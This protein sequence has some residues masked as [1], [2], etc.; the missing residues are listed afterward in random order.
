MQIPSN[1]W[2]QVRKESWI[3]AWI[4]MDNSWMTD[5]IPTLLRPRIPKSSCNSFSKGL[6]RRNSQGFYKISKT[7]MTMWKKPMIILCL[8]IRST[9]WKARTFISESMSFLTS[10]TISRES[11]LWS[12][13]VSTNRRVKSCLF[14]RR[15]SSRVDL[16][17][18][19]AGMLTG[20]AIQPS[21][22]LIHGS[23]HL[24]PSSRKNKK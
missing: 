10:K 12:S 13:S 5:W 17:K 16:Q 3:R 8:G 18:C 21:M 14:G 22:S 20:K 15:K 11:H 2:C 24:T 9:H 19:S 23:M 6:I 4:S 1:W 7:P